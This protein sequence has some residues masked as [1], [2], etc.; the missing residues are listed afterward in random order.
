MGDEQFERLTLG[1]EN[2]DLDFVTKM[3]TH[4]I[5]AM[6]MNDETLFD[7]N[8]LNFL[9][10]VIN[11][12]DI[13]LFNKLKKSY[14]NGFNPITKT[15]NTG[16]YGYID[17]NEK[18]EDLKKYEEDKTND[19]TVMPN[20]VW[21]ADPNFIYDG[22]VV[23][24]YKDEKGN[25]VEE[26][27]LIEN[28]W[29]GNKREVI[30]GK[31][32]VKPSM[33]NHKY[34]EQIKKIEDKIN[35]TYDENTID[36]L[37]KK[38]YK[39]KNKNIP[40]IQEHL[41]DENNTLFRTFRLDKMK[42]IKELNDDIIDLGTLKKK[43]DLLFK[44]NKIDKKDYN[45][46]NKDIDNDLE[47]KKKELSSLKS[48]INNDKELISEFRRNY[49]P[50]TIHMSASKMGVMIN[51]LNHSNKNIASE[52]QIKF[53]QERAKEYNNIPQFDKNGRIINFINK[54]GEKI[55]KYDMFNGSKVYML[56]G[57]FD[58]FIGNNYS[59]DIKKG[60]INP[61]N[62]LITH[63]LVE[64]AYKDDASSIGMYGEDYE[65]IKN[66]IK[67]KKAKKNKALKK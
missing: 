21:R 46:N 24:K 31:P 38:I 53:L 12:I 64:S 67:I 19:K 37:Q 42:E 20:A 44:L 22:F 7:N 65:I 61:K 1:I 25:I 11:S 9:L 45:L 41:I 10:N 15:L 57:Q 56:V 51:E 23:I 54:K 55:N 3:G 27:I 2:K 50:K 52:N 17:E 62:P 32:I 66:N 26:K 48:K 47:D 14:D 36:I 34:T 59:K 60:K 16:F 28:K 40:H 39:I 18:N 49:K 5:Y 63:R 29:Y 43:N 8:K 6:N 30:D 13:E 35:N 4:E 33:F 58:Y